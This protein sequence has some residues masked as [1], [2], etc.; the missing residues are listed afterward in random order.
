M[1][2]QLRRSA[3]VPLSLEL[4]GLLTA[5]ARRPGC[6]WCDLRVL[7]P[8][9]LEHR[10]LCIAVLPQREKLLVF[11][12]TGDRIPSHGICPRQAQMREGDGGRDGVD[13]IV[14]HNRLECCYRG[15][16]L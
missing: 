1:R 5:A 4:A 16:R 2:V 10:H 3:A 13:S 11:A 12:S 15:L 7:S 6:T 14:V 9:L 8:G